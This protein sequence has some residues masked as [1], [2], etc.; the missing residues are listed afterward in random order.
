M[1]IAWFTY[2]PAIAEQLVSE[3]NLNCSS[4]VCLLALSVFVALLLCRLLPLVC[5]AVECLAQIL[6]LSELPAWQVAIV[7]KTEKPL[8]RA[9][10]LALCGLLCDGL[11]RALLLEAE[12]QQGLRSSASA[13]AVMLQVRSFFKGLWTSFLI[14]NAVC[15]LY[16]IKDPPEQIVGRRPSTKGTWSYTIEMYYCALRNPRG[17]SKESFADKS[18]AVHRCVAALLLV[19]GILPWFR[20]FGIRPASAMAFGGLGTIALGIVSKEVLENLLSGLLLK[21]SKPFVSGDRIRTENGSVQGVV[22]RVGFAYSQLNTD[23]GETVMMP[24]SSLIKNATV[25]HTRD[26]FGCIQGRFPV[27]L[28]DFT[29]LGLLCQHVT[30]RV[31][32]HPD[33]ISGDRLRDMKKSDPKLRIFEP[34]CTFKGFGPA[35][36]LLEVLAY[37]PSIREP[38]FM[39]VESEV[40]LAAND[41]IA[42]FGGTI[43]LEARTSA[44]VLGRQFSVA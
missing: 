18:A 29:Q 5:I 40:L 11:V 35:G 33:V 34:Q 10:R 19:V 16:D 23:A 37:T 3:A 26:R 17:F 15:Y 12:Q 44:A 8:M 13:T 21:I 22:R 30:E 24:N 39:Q 38:R 20:L 32:Q 42:T 25:G 28:A 2:G 7:E 43:G 31:L 9:S 36:A 4:H 14:T 27:V 6:V 1:A 41:A